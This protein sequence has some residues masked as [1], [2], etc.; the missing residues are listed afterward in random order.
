MT[1][2]L[3]QSRVYFGDTDAAG[4]VYHG[5]YVYWME[6]A[7]IEW[8]MA[9][10]CP[11]S[12]FIAQDIAFIPVNLSLAFKTPLRFEDV[13][14]VSVSV[15]QLKR[16]SFSIDYVFTRQ[17]QVTATGIVTLACLNSTT[18]KPIGIPSALK[19]HLLTSV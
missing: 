8:L 1:P 2:F 3:W 17:A 18:F 7:R 13:F 14:E 9:I 5:R 4:I 11:Y 12:T 10:G 19:H 6:A 15:S 16:A